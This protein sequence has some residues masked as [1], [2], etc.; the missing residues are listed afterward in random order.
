MLRCLLLAVGT[1]LA[2]AQAPA[3]ACHEFAAPIMG[4]EVRILIHGGEAGEAAR[5]AA[6]AFTAVRV[7]DRIFS[8]HRNDSEIAALA[9]H[10]GDGSWVPSSRPLERALDLAAILHAESGGAFD[11][12]IG[13][14]TRLARETRREGRLP[15]QPE[16]EAARARSGFVHLARRPGAARLLVRGASLDFGGLAKGMAVDQ[17]LQ[18]LRSAGH[19]RSLVQAEGDLVAGEPPPG[20]SGWR[21]RLSGLPGGNAQG[22]IELPPWTALSVSG[23]TGQAL[24]VEGVRHSHLLEPGTGHSVPGRRFA[25]VLAASGLEAD[26]LATALCVVSEDRQERFLS[27][28]TPAAE[29]LFGDEGGVR[30]RTAGFPPFL[31]DAGQAHRGP[32]TR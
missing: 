32:E 18:E 4:V 9:A 11:V 14:L 30:G 31:P 1:A 17:A 27:A 8:D 12:A 26:P 10:A 13:A 29:A 7:L 21:I 16:L 15:T 2:R 25:V 6:R 20:R 3:A 24:V 5:A 19:A 22:L 28:F 23:D